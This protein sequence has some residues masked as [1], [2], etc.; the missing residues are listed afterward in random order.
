MDA[1]EFAEYID[2]HPEWTWKTEF[3]TFQQR[4]IRHR[5]VMLLHRTFGVHVQF[6][7][8]SNIL[9]DFLYGVLEPLIKAFKFFKAVLSHSPVV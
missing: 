3:V 2:E 9:L 8:M 6:R 1:Q 7:S 4:N 5:C